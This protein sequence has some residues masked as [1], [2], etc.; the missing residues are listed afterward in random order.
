MSDGEKLLVVDDD[1]MMVDFAQGV[2]TSLGYRTVA[3]MDAQTALR[4]LQQDHEIKAVMVDLRLGAG[5]NGA[6]LAQDM[7][8]LRPDLGVLLTSGAHGAL[9]TAG[10]DMPKTVGLLP[11][12][13]RRRDLED[14]LSR[15]L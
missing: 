11:K 4:V 3:A 8:A 7:L 9:Q 2:L 6:G 15:L 1:P 10:R 5:P 13:Y 12:P 14:C